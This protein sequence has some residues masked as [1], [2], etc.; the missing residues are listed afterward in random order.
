M[1]SWLIHALRRADLF[2]GRG[3]GGVSVNR[4]R[5]MSNSAHARTQAAKA[6]SRSDVARANA[7]Q[8]RH[9]KHQ[10][11]R[12]EQQRNP[13]PR[14]DPLAGGRAARALHNARRP[15]WRLPDPL[16]RYPTQHSINEMGVVG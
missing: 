14:L 7:G 10:R 6:R 16:I 12:Q 9:K 3:W 8:P 15:P 5:E 2:G 13:T 1:L 11:E 4:V